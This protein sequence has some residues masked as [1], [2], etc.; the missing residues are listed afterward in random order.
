MLQ[1]SFQGCTGQCRQAPVGFRYVHQGGA[2]QDIADAVAWLASDK[3]G[4]V[5]GQVIRVD[6]GMI[7]SI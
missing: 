3:A 5:T 6:G 7:K 4:Y 2:A 1:L